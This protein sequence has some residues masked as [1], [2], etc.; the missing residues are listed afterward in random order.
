MQRKLDQTLLSRGL[1]IGNRAKSFLTLYQQQVEYESKLKVLRT[2]RE[3]EKY[4][5][6]LNKLRSRIESDEN[7]ENEDELTSYER[8][9]Q[10]VVK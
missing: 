3:L 6:K 1:A 7:A 2:K 10:K 8:I 9:F 4:E 5:D